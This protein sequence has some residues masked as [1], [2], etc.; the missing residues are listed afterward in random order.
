VERTL[1]KYYIISAKTSAKYYSQIRESNKLKF[2]GRA[3]FGVN[4]INGFLTWCL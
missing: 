3:R 1:A 2:T 4:F